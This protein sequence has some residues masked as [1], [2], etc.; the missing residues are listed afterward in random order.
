MKIKLGVF[1]SMFVLLLGVGF[2][3]AQE[4]AGETGAP[5]YKGWNLIYG[6]ISPDQLSGHLEKSSIKAVYAFN[7]AIQ[8][9][10]RMYPNREDSKITID[11]DL[12]LQTAFWVYSDTETGET[13]N[14]M[15]NGDEYWMYKL[16]QPISDLQLYSGWN[17]VAIVPEMIGKNLD[18]LKGSCIITR[19]YWWQPREQKFISVDLTNSDVLKS[20][21]NV[22]SG[23]IIKVSSNCK[24]GSVEA[25]VPSVP[26]LP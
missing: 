22:M 4:W 23:M 17:F 14:G 19:A 21:Q 13:L 15:Y 1:V 2:V 3:I 26:N 12:L 10:A 9:Y 8:Q 25:N 24:L 7:P 11:D 20:Q 6:F 5:I 16:P 18:E